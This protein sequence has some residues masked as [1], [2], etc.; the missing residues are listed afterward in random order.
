MNIVI[1]G[2]TRDEASIMKNRENNNMFGA[3]RT[4]YEASFTWAELLYK[5][6]KKKICPACG[7]ELRSNK[8]KVDVGVQRRQGFNG[9][10]LPLNTQ[11]YAYQQFYKCNKCDRNYPIAKLL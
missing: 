3:V 4:G 10:I 2:L 7:S 5:I 8:I 1:T 11:V 9:N 6:F